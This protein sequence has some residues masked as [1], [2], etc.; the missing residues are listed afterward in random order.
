MD[1]TLLVKLKESSPILKE[2]SRDPRR[3]L[4]SSFGY[5]IENESSKNLTCFE[6][7]EFLGL[8]V[9][10]FFSFWKKFNFWS[11]EFTSYYHTLSYDALREENIRH[12]TVHTHAVFKKNC[13]KLLSWF[14]FEI[15]LQCAQYNRTLDLLPNEEMSR[16]SNNCK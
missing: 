4:Y 8:L 5:P 7:I 9:G 6:K 11:L 12:G 3:A 14:T 13:S 15:A 2:W 1:K 10:F 16:K